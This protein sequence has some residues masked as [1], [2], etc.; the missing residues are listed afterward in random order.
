M[1][2][3]FIPHRHDAEAAAQAAAA[4]HDS[5]PLLPNALCAADGESELGRVVGSPDDVMR[6]LVSGLSG[7]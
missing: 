6:A 3:Y 2:A 7:C 1:G 5:P 4:L